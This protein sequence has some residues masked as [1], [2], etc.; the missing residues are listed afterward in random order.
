MLFI[1][2]A[3]KEKWFK[4]YKSLTCSPKKCSACKK[5]SWENGK[6]EFWISKDNV[7]YLRTCSQCGEQQTLM[8]PKSIKEQR[9]LNDTIFKLSSSCSFHSSF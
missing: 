1:L 5:E 7:G 3:S 8:T 9:K 6:F 4:K 2:N